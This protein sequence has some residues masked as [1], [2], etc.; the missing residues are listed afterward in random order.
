M[1]SWR[2]SPRSLLLIVGI[3]M[4]VA[5]LPAI[6][7]CTEAPSPFHKVMRV[8][9]GES[10]TLP[11]EAVKE[12]AR[13]DEVYR[14]YSSDPSNE[15]RLEYF[16]FAYKR[17]R[18]SYVR[19]VSDTKLI[20]AAIKAVTEKTGTEKP[21]VPSAL[22]ETALNSMVSSL[23]PHSA[24]LNADQFRE[25]FVHTKG[26][27]GGLGIEVTME[28]G[29]VKVVAPIEDT[30]AARAGL[31]T[32]DLITHVDGE[33]IKGKTL[34]EAVRTMRGRPGTDIDLRIRREGQT[35][36]NVT[37]TRAVIKVQ[38]VRWRTEGNIAY[39]RI[40]R[41]SEKMESGIEEAFDMIS[42]ELG[43]QLAG[44]I[45]DLRNNPGGLLD[46]SIV[47]AD[48]FLDGGEIVSVRGRTRENYRLFNARVG[49]LARGLPIVVLI[50]GGSASAS[51]IVA[52]ALKHHGRALVMG[53]RSFGK[54]SV[55]TIMPLPIEGALRLTTALYYAPSGQ[56]IQARGVLPDITL[57]PKKD[58]KQQRESDLPG[59]L[60]AEE[61]LEAQNRQEIPEDRCPA[62]GEKKDR[63]L[64]CALVFLRAGSVS[65]LRDSLGKRDAQM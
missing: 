23:D 54:G 31:L 4:A 6:S 33:A 36:F 25:T 24:Y 19:P 15:E 9:G 2:G 3:M 40:A 39:L 29:L 57:T 45:L 59:A 46:Q 5:L 34:L 53:T 55:Q 8:I 61:A 27:F 60:P 32:G 20:D 16:Q 65:A 22:V 13:F 30:P 37:I 10:E 26:E 47:L 63:P 48:Q 43:E 14:K 51:E 64:G 28:E 44:V 56:T 41:F 50:N 18:A 62:I 11:P 17:L 12:L 52:S 7:A 42:T 49:D 58:N 38:A 21:L 1:S 35:D